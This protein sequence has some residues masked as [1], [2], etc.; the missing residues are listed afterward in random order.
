M[1]LPPQSASA[2]PSE[3]SRIPTSQRIL[4]VGGDSRIGA[5]L[6]LALRAH[7]AK[8][9]ATTRR[10]E[11]IAAAAPLLDLQDIES[12][13]ALDVSTYDIAYLCAGVS[14]FA[15]CE[16]GDLARRVNVDNTLHLCERLRGA[17][18]AIFFL[19]TSAVFDGRQ[20]D[21]S[22]HTQPTPTT[23]YG[24]QKAEVEGALCK[25]NMAQHPL[26]AIVRL[27]KVLTPDAP[28]VLDWRQ[29]LKQKGDIHPLADLWLSPISLAYAVEG[30]IVLGQV[31]QGGVFHLSGE[32]DV[33]YADCAI[34]LAL[35]WGEPTRRVQPRSLRDAGINLPYCP[36]YPTLVMTRTTQLTGLAPQPFATCMDE[37]AR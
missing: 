11:N 6:C 18:C 25:V 13:N 28:I 5:A 8:V 23:A 19:S 16:E 24:R 35:R 7:G 14:T 3:V 10:L 33:S 12:I 1:A 34:A 9:T 31:G 37:V 26:A 32:R 17:G 29:Q 30:L 4:I 21:A 2:I 22:E 20:P 15:A 27:S 36:A